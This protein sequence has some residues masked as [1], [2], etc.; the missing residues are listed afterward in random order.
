MAIAIITPYKIY[1]SPNAKQTII[2]IRQV[3][4][5][6]DLLNVAQLLEKA[7]NQLDYAQATLYFN[8]CQLLLSQELERDAA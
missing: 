8:Q 7:I 6:S 5:D 4:S 3:L 2:N 1:C